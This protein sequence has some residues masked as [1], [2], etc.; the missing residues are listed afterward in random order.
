[1]KDLT[2]EVH[3]GPAKSGCRQLNIILLGKSWDLTEPKNL[4]IDAR[5]AQVK[6]QYYLHL[7]YFL[8][9]VPMPSQSRSWCFTWN[10]PSGEPDF[11]LYDV[12]YSVYSHEIGDSG[13]P[14]IQGFL[15]FATKCSLTA[16]IARIHEICDREAPHVEMM[17]G[18][19][20]QAAAYCKKD[21]VD[22]PY[23]GVSVA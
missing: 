9:L 13:T 19:P 11:T 10:N 12:S 4:K 18:T 23:E 5:L 3:R 17:R 1:M 2:R 15:Q 20:E 22:G 14:H 8:H 16:A 21:P 6:I 7:G